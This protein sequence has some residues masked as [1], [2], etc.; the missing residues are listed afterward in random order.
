MTEMGLLLVPVARG[1][2]GGSAIKAVGELFAADGSR[3]VVG[4]SLGTSG[5]APSSLVA[6]GDERELV[7]STG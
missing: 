2:E 4:E 5:T 7:F 6:I 3:S 1:L